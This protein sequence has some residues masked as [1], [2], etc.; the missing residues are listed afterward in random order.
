[1]IDLSGL[2]EQSFHVLG[3]GLTGESAARALRSAGKRVTVWDDDEKACARAIA[4]GYDV[5]QDVSS[6]TL[7][8]SPGIVVR[9]G[10]AHPMVEQ[11]RTKNIP[12]TNDVALFRRVLPDRKLVA[13]TGTNGKSTTTA[14]TGHILQQAE[15]N[16][17]VGGNLG[18]PVLDLD[19]DADAFVLELSSYQLELAHNLNATC[20]VLLNITPDHIDHH[21]D[22]DS[23]VSAKMHVFDGA[24]HRIEAETL[25][26]QSG[27]INGFDARHLPRLRGEHNWQNIA[28]GFAVCRALGI[29]D[30]AIW[31]GVES[32]EG[33][34]HRQFL[35]RTI[36][37]VIY[38]NDSKA[39]NADAVQKALRSFDN[40][41]LIAGG[42]PKEGGLNGLENDLGPVRH[43]YLI[44]IA[45]DEFAAWLDAHHVA[46]T[47][48][49]VM[50]AA[51]AEAHKDAQGSGGAATV[52]LSPACASFDQF[53]SFPHRGR[54]FEELVNAL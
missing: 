28:A 32:F 54:V 36:G 12:L 30:A 31:H 38:I 44:G 10:D 45:A 51:V 24:V 5:S 19:G 42:L 35:V 23:Y 39:T 18:T 6:D 53:D 49:G 41:Y 1:M 3:Y 52:L 46:Y 4:D 22:M 34:P 2:S 15:V 48:S 29:D 27:V 8:V 33:L 21:G 17:A 13:I 16:V 50:D 47:K 11:A 25:D 9:E 14:L 7:L 40:I 37:D 43:A 20:A 26:Y